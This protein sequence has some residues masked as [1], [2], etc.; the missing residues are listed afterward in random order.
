MVG[1][2]AAVSCDESEAAGSEDLEATLVTRAEPG[3]RA[4]VQS[5]GIYLQAAGNSFL[6]FKKNAV[7]S[8]TLVKVSSIYYQ[9]RLLSHARPRSHL[10]PVSPLH[11]VRGW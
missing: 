5:R 8:S 9:P 2:S 3:Y 11:L 6:T 7:P 4:G 10:I 1:S